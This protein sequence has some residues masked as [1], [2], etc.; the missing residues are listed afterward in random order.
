MTVLHYVIKY[1]IVLSLSHSKSQVNRKKIK[2]YGET[3]HGDS[4]SS[5]PEI[6]VIMKL[7]N[8]VRERY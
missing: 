1:F 3:D 5:R 8:F 7:F 6:S 4:F 2:I